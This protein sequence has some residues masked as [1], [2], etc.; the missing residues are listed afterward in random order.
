MERT[1]AAARWSIASNSALVAGKM[2]VGISTNSVSII[3]EAI[4]SGMDLA[5][6]VIAYASI[7]AARR[8]A[9]EVHQYGHGKIENVSGSIEAVLIL[10]AAAWIVYDAMS[11]LGEGPALAGLGLGMAVMG[12]SAGVNWFLSRYLMRVARQEES[13]A[14][15]ADA[16]HLRTDVYTSAGV[17]TGLAAIYFTGYLLLDSLIALVVALMII[18]AGFNLLREAAL[19]LVDVRLPAGEEQAIRAIIEQHAGQYVE[20]HRLRTRRAGRERYVDLHLVVPY[21]LHVDDVHRICEDIEVEVAAR[22]PGSQVLIHVE[23]CS[24]YCE[25]GD[26]CA[27]SGRNGTAGREYHR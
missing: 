13:I 24:T 17:A 26:E 8:P 5:A 9:D 20:F 23:P 14:L 4:H 11:S 25:I 19:P 3:S 18:R 10:L 12:V 22:L 16:L 6:A 15:E 7:R 2:A 21:N 1:E 27:G